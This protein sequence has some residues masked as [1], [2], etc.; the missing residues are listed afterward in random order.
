MRLWHEELINKLPRQQLLGQHRECCALRGNGWGKR[1]S[2]VDYVF[3]HSPYKLYRYHC[4]V[5]CEMEKRGY[6]PNEKWK[7]P[8]YRGEKCEPYKVL[9]EEHISTPIYLE[10]N[11]KYMKECLTNLAEKDIRLDF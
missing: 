4:L 7:N 1:H 8:L 11:A 10:H 5:M 2:V 9:E 6:K 3:T